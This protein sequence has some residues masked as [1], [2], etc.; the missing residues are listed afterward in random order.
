MG[1]G[2]IMR[3]GVGVTFCLLLCLGTNAWGFERLSAFETSDMDRYQ[4]L[5]NPSPVSD[6]RR[7]CFI[8]QESLFHSAILLNVSDIKTLPVPPGSASLFLCAMASFGVWKAKRKKINVNR[9]LR[10]YLNSQSWRGS[11][12]M[13]FL[14]GVILYAL[15]CL[16]AQLLA[17]DRLK[18]SWAFRAKIR[19]DQIFS[20][21]IY[22]PRSPPG[23]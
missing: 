11:R 14:Y 12:R 9:C 7:T 5:F 4:N 3:K 20:L 2:K 13:L 18:L 16:Y 6:T 21:A 1:C 8:E 22:R 10:E 15:W 19:G 23:N 17:L